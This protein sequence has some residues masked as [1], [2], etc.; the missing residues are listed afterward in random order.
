MGNM[1]ID[2]MAQFNKPK[3]GHVFQG[4]GSCML[5]V[6]HLCC[7]VQCVRRNRNVHQGV[8][9]NPIIHI[10]F[11][12]H[13]ARYAMHALPWVLKVKRMYISYKLGHLKLSPLVAMLL[14]Q[15]PRDMHNLGCQLL[16]KFQLLPE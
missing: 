9:S 5:H 8:I 2:T 4:G 7:A 14:R 10:D 15:I 12:L 11:L 16:A 6:I 13:I 3:T 1:K